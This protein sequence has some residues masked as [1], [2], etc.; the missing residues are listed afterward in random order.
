MN[1][2]QVR[3]RTRLR[4]GLREGGR[5]AVGEESKQLILGSEFKT[6]DIVR[7]SKHRFEL[8]V[9]LIANKYYLICSATYSTHFSLPTIDLQSIFWDPS[10]GSFSKNNI[11]FSKSSPGRKEFPPTGFLAAPLRWQNSKLVINN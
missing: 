10:A 6:A 4:V 1:K 2:A 7:E 8:V 5:A 9:R 3:S 11:I